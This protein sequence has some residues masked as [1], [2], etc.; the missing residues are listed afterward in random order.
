MQSKTNNAIIDPTPTAPPAQGQ[1]PSASPR[2]A[3]E[4]ELEPA[5]TSFMATLPEGAG[6]L[7]VEVLQGIRTMINSGLP[8]LTELSHGGSFTVEETA[9]PGL[10]DAPPVPLLVF[11]PTWTERPSGCIFWVHGGGMVFGSNREGLREIL[12]HAQAVSAVVISVDY[13]L[14]PE[15]AHPGPVED[16]YAGLLWTA[17]HLSEWSVPADCLVLAGGSAGGGLAA[18]AALMSRDLGGPELRGQMLLAPMLDHRNDTASMAQL[19]D[20]A[21]WTR[22]ANGFGWNSLLGISG[23][24]NVSPYASPSLARDLTRLPVSYI[25]VGGADGFRDEDA[26]YALRLGRAGVLVEFHIWPG[27]Y[28]GFEGMVPDAGVSRAALAARE[29]WLARLLRQR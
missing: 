8:T 26:E 3:V 29:R 13:R 7:S 18:A 4:P 24:G 9:A 14:A 6:A 1:S 11:R 17:E 15:T 12:D 23:S 25:D 16:C 10:N 21:I 27:G 28:H 22:D 19:G 20:A 5:L 2:P